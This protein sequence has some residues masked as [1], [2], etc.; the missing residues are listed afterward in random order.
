M[1]NPIWQE[2]YKVNTLLIN[3]RK[4]LGLVGLLAV[5]QDAAGVHA[6]QLGYGYEAMLKDNLIWVLL[7]QKLV[8]T[9]WPAWGETVKIQTWPRPLNGLAALRDFEIFA[10]GHKVGECVTSWMML[11]LTTRKPVKPE[12]NSERAAFRTD[13]SLVFEP[14]KLIVR[15]GLEP[16]A[17][18]EVRNSDLDLH[19]HVNNTRYAQWI[20]DAVPLES[21]QKYR[22]EE[23]EVNFLN[24]TRVGDK[25]KL[26]YGKVGEDGA[27]GEVYRFQGSRETDTKP[28][29]VAE[30]RV[31]MLE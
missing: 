9:E 4:R 22:L 8:M 5:L 6:A 29:F 14:R 25:I 20:L 13:F 11:D 27:K 28:A 26:A 30:L 1:I 3:P 15:E 21:L 18:L 7:R 23:Y 19:E 10:E 17:T 2:E 12:I 16:L 24:E 31:T